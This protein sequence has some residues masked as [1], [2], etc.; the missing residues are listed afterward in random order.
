M[1]I[2]VAATA[3]VV[4]AVATARVAAASPER[5]ETLPEPAALP[6]PAATGD[7]AVDDVAIHYA[8]FGTGPAIV[9]L[10]GG[11]GSG[12]QFGNQVPAFAEH[13]T[14][15]VIDSR[16]QGRSTRSKHALTYH[17][18]AEDV[19]AVLD[20]LKLDR[21]AVVGWSDGGV[22]GLDLAIHHAD[23]LT[24]L[25]VIGTNY[26]LSGMRH[27]GTT[28]TFTQYFKR[29][30]AA[31]KKL[32]PSPR[33]LAAVQK[34]L[35]AMWKSEPTYTEDELRAITTPMLVAL[36]DHDEIIARDHAEK[37]AKLVPGA[38]LAILDTVS[39]FAMWQDPDGF[40]R[41]VLDFV[42]AR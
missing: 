32:A 38:K 31:Y 6:T 18:M 10:H 20:A 15:V 22:I 1:R 7:V 12:E 34:Q 14:V 17:V 23:R 25:F 3:A 37:M 19:I 41:A 21:A 26:D 42:D 27:Q 13:H 35:R 11:L 9:L 4:V 39:H 40:N 8:T 29:A 24:K 5:W 16:G 2:A 36:G 30:K 33:Q 28:K